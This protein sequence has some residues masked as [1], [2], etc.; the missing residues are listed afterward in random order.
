[1]H[2]TVRSLRHR[3]V[4]GS[5]GK[6]RDFSLGFAPDLVST[7]T[8]FEGQGEDHRSGE[9]LRA[10]W[11]LGHGGCVNTASWNADGTLLATGSDDRCVKVR[12]CSS[13]RPR[14]R[15]RLCRCRC[16]GPPSGTPAVVCTTPFVLHALGRVADSALVVAV[17]PHISYAP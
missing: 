10:Q 16:R 14:P 13:P 2:S 6:R 5:P 4:P 17:H 9:A 3:Q 11:R 1:M 7:F 15:P 12:P 8:H